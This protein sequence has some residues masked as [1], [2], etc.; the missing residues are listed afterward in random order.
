VLTIAEPFETIR[1][2]KGNNLLLPVYAAVLAGVRRA[3]DDWVP[4]HA[5]ARFRAFLGELGLTVLDDCVFRRIRQDDGLLG[6]NRSPT[7]KAAGMSKKV[8]GEMQDATMHVVISRHRSWAE[9]TLCAAWYP[10]GIPEHRLLLRP[11]IDSVRLGS[12]FGYPDCCVESFLRSNHWRIYSHLSESARTSRRFDW[13]ANCLTRHTPYMTSF[14]TP[15]RFDCEQTIAM[16]EAVL[17]A[18]DT[19]DSAFANTIAAR[20]RGTFL[21]VNEATVFRLED[22]VSDGP[23]RVRFSSVENM[24]PNMDQNGQVRRVEEV[25]AGATRVEL[26]EGM[27]LASG[28][29]ERCHEAT[30]EGDWIEDPYLATFD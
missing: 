28:E 11:R 12:A 21:M 7:T 29:T 26:F 24:C 16:T 1:R 14:H 9:E 23:G 27:I 19:Y 22:A 17:S 13:R 18:V 4:F 30:A 5:L 2:L 25:L 20:Q 8:A 6:L 3:M 10:V 15:C